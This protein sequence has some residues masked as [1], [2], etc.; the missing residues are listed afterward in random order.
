MQSA[1]SRP[2]R[3]PLAASLIQ[4]L[5]HGDRRFHIRKE[6]GMCDLPVLRA[7]RVEHGEALIHSDPAAC[8]LGPHALIEHQAP[9]TEFESLQR[10]Y[11]Q[12][13]PGLAQRL[14][15]VKDFLAP[16]HRLYVGEDGRDVEDRVL[17]VDV[18]HLL[19]LATVP[20]VELLVE[21]MEKFRGEGLGDVTSLTDAI[22]SKAP[23]SMQ[24]G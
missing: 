10:V 19:K 1:A 20:A 2:K 8:A 23:L 15:V 6:L 4:R 7:D 9:L 11:A 5:R 18:E 13:V 21:L 24:S 14:P 16:M 12:A 17:R 22:S 3:R